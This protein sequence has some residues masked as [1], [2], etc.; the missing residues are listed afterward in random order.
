MSHLISFIID[1]NFLNY[2]SFVTWPDHRELSSVIVVS[3]QPLRLLLLDRYY[4]F[5]KLFLL[6]HSWGHEYSVLI[7]DMRLAFNQNVKS[8]RKLINS[9]IYHSCGFMTNMNRLI[10]ENNFILLSHE[11]INFTASLISVTFLRFN[12]GRVI[13][14]KLI[15]RHV[16]TEADD[17]QK[18]QPIYATPNIQYSFTLLQLDNEIKSCVSCE[19]ATTSRIRSQNKLVYCII[20]NWY[21]ILFDQKGSHNR[22]M[23]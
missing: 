22:I 4:T 13:V 12:E 16:A 7:I 6:C 11:N 5:E 19:S 23:T 9:F 14:S 1:A 2:F 17:L 18:L 15:H 21:L 3:V 20:I 8:V 10:K